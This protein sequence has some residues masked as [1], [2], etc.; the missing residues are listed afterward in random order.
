MLQRLTIK[1]TLTDWVCIEGRVQRKLTNFVYTV[2]CTKEKVA[3]IPVYIY[4]VIKFKNLF[5]F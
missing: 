1:A 3:V 5:I 4:P 2:Q